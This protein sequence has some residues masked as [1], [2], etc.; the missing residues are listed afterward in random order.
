[1]RRRYSAGP[2]PPRADACVLGQPLAIQNC[3]AVMERTPCTVDSRSSVVLGLVLVLVWVLGLVL[4]LV[5]VLE[6]A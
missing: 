5:L 4:V 6:L 1:V 3:D 2:C